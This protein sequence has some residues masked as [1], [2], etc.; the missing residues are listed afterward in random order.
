MARLMKEAIEV[1]YD[2][3]IGNDKKKIKIIKRILYVPKKK[4]N[5]IEQ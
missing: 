5:I 1:L 2:S 3:K 4:K